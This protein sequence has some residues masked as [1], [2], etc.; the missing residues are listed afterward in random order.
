MSFDRDDTGRLAREM[1]A[2]ARA[3]TRT[4]LRKSK[5]DYLIERRHVARSLG[6]PV[7]S[8]TDLAGTIRRMNSDGSGDLIADSGRA[9]LVPATVGATEWQLLQGQRISF[10]ADDEMDIVVRIV[11]KL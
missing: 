4:A 1:T 11:T 6:Y 8:R 10:E 2:A 7:K 5:G 3:A 9:F